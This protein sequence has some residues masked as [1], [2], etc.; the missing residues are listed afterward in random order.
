MEEGSTVD[1]HIVSSLCGGTG[2]AC[3]L[4]MSYLVRHVISDGPKQMTNST[5]HLL[6]SEPFENEPGIGPSSREYIHTN[7]AV[8]LSEVEHFTQKGVPGLWDV[9]YR[10]GTRVS[11]SEKPFNVAYLMGCKQ[12]VTLTKDHVCEII[13]ETIAINTVH[14]EGRR[15]KGVIENYK[16]HVINTQ[17]ARHKLRT[18]SSHNSYI[19]NLG[20]DTNLLE[21]A[22][23]SAAATVL[24]SLCDQSE[25]QQEVQRQLESF[26]K[27]VFANLSGVHSNKFEEFLDHFNRKVEIVPTQF[28]EAWRAVKNVAAWP[29]KKLR[30]EGPLQAAKVN[31]VC[32]DVVQ[33]IES[34]GNLFS[35]TLADSHK[36]LEPEIDVAISKLLAEHSIGFVKRSQSLGALLDRFNLDLQQYLTSLP[37]L[38]RRYD[39]EIV[40]AIVAGR[41]QVIPSICAE[42]ASA[43]WHRPILELI[44]T[45]LEELNREIDARKRWCHS[46]QQC[47]TEAR[48][49]FTELKKAARSSYT[50]TFVWTLDELEQLFAT[51]PAKSGS[52]AGLLR[53]WN[54]IP[55]SLSRIQRSVFCDS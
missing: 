4:D 14:P 7:F 13:G 9:E 41:G 51:P 54:T 39:E 49:G 34:A 29:D 17:D 37:N 40:N 33:A 36:K 31:L 11:S 3:L 16:P 43:T 22:V 30:K 19:F 25:L 55:S 15:I 50:T 44:S 21:S 2:S 53:S 47:L 42:R 45:R 35:W 48:H 27:S 32:E 5:A 24:G 20:V 6:T 52:Q 18:Y 26:G 8:A 46:A 12:G 1:V 28:T 23:Q 38:N 10:A